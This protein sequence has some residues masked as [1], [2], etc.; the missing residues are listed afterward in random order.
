MKKL[1]YSAFSMFALAPYAAYAAL[2]DAA[3]ELEKV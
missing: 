2:S 3:G 1:L